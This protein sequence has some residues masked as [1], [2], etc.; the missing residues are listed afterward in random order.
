MSSNTARSRLDALPSERV[1]W[2]GLLC[3]LELLAVVSY[4]R[5]TSSELI[6]VRYVLYP[7]VWINVG[8]LAVVATDPVP[9]SRRHRRLGIAVGIGYFLLLAWFAGLVS[10]VP[11]GHDHAAHASHGFSL[12]M[13]SPGWGPTLSYSGAVFQFS[14]VPFR[15]VG[16]L[17]LSYLVY[18]TVLDSLAASA[19]GL[20]GLFSCVSCAFPLLSSLASGT[21]G[22]AAAL[23]TVYAFGVDLS[24]LVFVVAVALLYW[25]P[26]VPSRGG[27]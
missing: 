3:A 4:F 12:A 14:L 16:Y 17:A 20:V 9:T 10:L 7:F 27:A 24:T 5:F 15:V 21:A 23:A 26:G 18:A 25:R 2:L 1:L 22:S 6:S 11:A 19:T 8:L 13:P